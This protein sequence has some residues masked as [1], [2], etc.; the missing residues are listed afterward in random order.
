MRAVYYDDDIARTQ[1]QRRLRITIFWGGVLFCCAKALALR[2]S[3]TRTL[4]VLRGWWGGRL[5]RGGVPGFGPSINI[6]SS[7]TLEKN[8]SIRAVLGKKVRK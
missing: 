2:V 4:N 1:I 3:F 5:A 8:K 7:K 6:G